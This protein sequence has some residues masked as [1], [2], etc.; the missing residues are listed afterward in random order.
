MLTNG[1]LTLLLV[2]MGLGLLYAYRAQTPAVPTVSITEA[3]TDVS[4]GRIRTVTITGTRASLEY[5]ETAARKQT[6]LPEGAHGDDPLTQA[7]VAYNNANPT[8]AIALRYEQTDPGISVIGSVLLSLLPVVLIGG[9]F[10]YMLNAARSRRR[11]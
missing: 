2:V 9:F 8:R 10:V 6:V 5:A 7:I 4:A 11:E 3:I 1:L